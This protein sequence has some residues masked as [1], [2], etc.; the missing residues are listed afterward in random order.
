MTKAAS[1]PIGLIFLL[2]TAAVVRAQT[3]PANPAVDVAIRR[4]ADTILLRQKLIDAKAAWQRK[5]LHAA[6]KL[7]EDAYTLV[8]GIGAASVEAERGQTVA[9][10][11]A[12]RMELARAAQNSGDLKEADT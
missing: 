2:A 9:G 5:D 8:Q 1:L 7:Y 3:P 4:Q 10:L 6:A 11:I 12:V